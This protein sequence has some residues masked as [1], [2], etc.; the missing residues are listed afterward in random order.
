L[1]SFYVVKKGFWVS[2]DVFP[3]EGFVGPAL[4]GFLL[5]REPWVLAGNDFDFLKS[6]DAPFLTVFL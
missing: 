6:I 2:V 5:E 3:F 4:I 1:P